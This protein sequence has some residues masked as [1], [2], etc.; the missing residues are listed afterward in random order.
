MYRSSAWLAA[1]L[2][3]SSPALAATPWQSLGA[4]LTDREI[5]S[6]DIDV[7]PDGQGLPPGKGSVEEGQAIYDAQC[8][9]CHGVFGESN[10][11][12]ALTGGIG[13][14]TSETPQRTVASKLDYATTLWDY[15]N[16]AMPFTHAKVLGVNEVYA[17]T[18]YV[19]N[20]AEIL[21]MD[22]TLDE[23]TL[24]LVEMPNRKGYTQAHGFMTVDGKPDVQA[25]AC[26]QDCAAEVTVTS[27]L[28][29][30]FTEEMYG[31]IRTH[32]RG[33]AGMTTLPAASAKPPAETLAKSPAELAATH[34][35]LTCHGVDQAIVG[36]AFT[37]I[38]ERYADTPDA[39]TV[40]A[41]KV[42]AGGSGVWGSAMMPAQ[43]SIPDETLA[44]VLAWL[45]AG[46]RAK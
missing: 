7:R 21:P 27:E 31:D 8:A 44:E 1:L 22:A 6:W 11:Y 4:P 23:K 36:P 46:A 19:L 29:A 32:F 10:D 3:C 35:C 5:S 28:P 25:K 15:I 12:I 26:M 43:T 30:G 38:A 33:L 18:A 16:R 34:G 41:A 42:R 37:A 9:S 40:L 39:G 17:V 24:P 2:V 45:L 14:L 20:L 13:T